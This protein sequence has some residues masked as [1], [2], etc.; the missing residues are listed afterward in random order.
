LPEKMMIL[1]DQGPIFAVVRSSTER[2]RLSRYNVALR[3]W[4]AAED[5]AD[6]ELLAFKGQTVAGH[7]LVTDP[8]TLIRL[9]EGGQLD[10]DAF[11]HSVGGGR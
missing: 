10:F 4:R 1:T 7:V 11:Y 9:E 5:G 6:Q 8:D 3:K 2:T